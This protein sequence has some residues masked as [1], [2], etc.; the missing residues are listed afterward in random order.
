MSAKYLD[1]LKEVVNLPT[2]PFAEGHV[3]AYL[4]ALVARHP[5][6]RLKADRFGNLLVKYTPKTTRRPPAGRRPLLFAAHMDHP[7]FIAGRMIAPHRLQ[8]E[9]HGGVKPSFFKNGKIRFRADGRW[10]PATIEKVI[11]QKRKKGDRRPAG[12]LPPEAVV[13]KVSKPVPPGSLGMWHLPDAVIRGHRLHARVTDDLSG[14]AA[15]VCTLEAICRRRVQAPCYAFFT[16]AEE[17]GFAGAL[18]AVDGRTV[19]RGAIVVAVE[20]SSVI[21]GVNLGRGPVLRVGDKMSVFTPAAT[22]YCQAVADELAGKDKTFLYQRK[23]MDGG[24]CESTA[25]CHWGYDATGI[26][27]ALANYHNMDTTRRKIA[28]ES[29]DVRD[30]LNLVKWFIALA[31]SPARFKFT[32]PNPGLAKRLTGLLKQHRRR[33]VTT[34]MC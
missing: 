3:I 15:I 14:L 26:C 20:N 18:A 19:P 8:A 24:S 10:I 6:L 33:L 16:R 1:T 30:Y 13:A 7:G 32:D 34:A 25:Y 2:A 4:R 9:W 21:P 12:D 17:V 5:E 23:L 28:P 31:Q 22:A 27:L 29:I 11:P